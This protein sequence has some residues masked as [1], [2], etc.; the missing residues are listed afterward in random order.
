MQMLQTLNS[1]PGPKSLKSY[2][3]FRETASWS[4]KRVTQRPI[5]FETVTEDALK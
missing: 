2:R 3:D 5:T 4:E 1:F